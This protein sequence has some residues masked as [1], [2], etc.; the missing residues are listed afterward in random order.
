[1]H[2]SP[3]PAVALLHEVN[4]RDALPLPHRH[5]H[6]VRQGTRPTDTDA[7]GPHLGLALQADEGVDVR[8]T[9]EHLNRR[10]GG[11]DLL[12]GAGPRDEELD[13]QHVAALVEREDGGHPRADPLEVLRR[14]DDPHEGD[15]AGGDGAVGEA[16]DQVADVADLVGDADAAGE[17]EDGAVGAEGVQPA[18]RAF[19]QRGHGEAAPGLF[20]LLVQ[21][22]SEA[23]A[24]TD[25]GRDGGL[26]QG[27]NVLAVHSEAFFGVE[28]LFGVG[29]GDGEGV[30][31]P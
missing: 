2:P 11:V 14:L 24:A 23:V 12:D 20:R 5:P 4:V 26:L 17:D 8:P 10:A 25:D 13:A 21:R 7:H 18:V 15:A 29:P 1:M 3:L 6:I 31:C 9:G 19:D 28:T 22:V 27:E 30:G 16:D